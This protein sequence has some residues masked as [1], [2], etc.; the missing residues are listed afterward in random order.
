MQRKLYAT[1]CASAILAAGV[2]VSLVKTAPGHDAALKKDE[3]AERLAGKAV[4][5][6]GNPVN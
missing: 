2:I 1:L 3:A 4:G 5:Q 6:Q